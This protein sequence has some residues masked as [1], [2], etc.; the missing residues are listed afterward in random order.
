MKKKISRLLRWMRWIIIALIILPVVSMILIKLT[1]SMEFRI[2]D[3]QILGALYDPGLHKSIDTVT[4]GSR[5]IVYLKTWKK[6]NKPEAIVFV[7]GA[8]GSLDDFLKYMKDDTLLA[9]ADLIAYDRPGYGHSNFGRSLSSLRSQAQVL[10]RLMQELGYKKYWLVGHSYGAAIIVQAA[11]NDPRGI[12]GLGIISGAIVYEVEPDAAWRKWIDLPFIR[13][14]LPAALRVS[15]DE[16]MSLK[17]HLR[18]SDDDW[19][20]ITMP[21]TLIHGTKDVLVPYDHLPHAKQKL[22]NSDSVR[23]LII[24]DENHFILWKNKSE[25][26]GEIAHL[27]TLE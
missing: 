23:T 9:R 17:R 14:L 13:M 11:L 6:K 25:I 21:V 19:D 2:S 24:E 27:L 20:Q 10:Q 5:R 1:G 15:N 3:D 18:M 16:L 4:I 26:S 12:A 22:I 8:P 7:H